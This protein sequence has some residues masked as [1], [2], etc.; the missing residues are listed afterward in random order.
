MQSLLVDRGKLELKQ[1]DGY[2]HEFEDVPVFLKQPLIADKRYLDTKITSPVRVSYAPNDEKLFSPIEDRYVGG[3][4]AIWSGHRSVVVRDPETRQL[5]RLKGIAFNEEK[6]EIKEYSPGAL[7]VDG[8]QFLRYAVN[9]KI[10]SDR[11]NHTLRNN[12]MEPVMEVIGLYEYPKR[13]GRQ[14]IAATISRIK[15]DTRLDELFCMFELLYAMNKIHENN[16]EDLKK[17]IE[18][19]YM[20][21]GF[22]SGAHKKMMTDNKQTWSAD[23]N[24]TNAHFGNI[25]VYR[26][27]YARSLDIGFVDFDSS[28]KPSEVDYEKQIKA[29]LNSMAEKAKEKE[30]SMRLTH[31]F[32]TT[33]IENLRNIFI[34]GFGISYYK[35]SLLKNADKVISNTF[36]LGYNYY[37][38]LVTTM[39]DFINKVHENDTECKL[40]TAPKK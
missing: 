9:E 24:I 8:G 22:I 28:C 25:V 30:C 6:P 13:V 15:G 26:S 11:F 27:E 2:L 39:T 7:Y 19:F 31:H 33:E 1:T 20:I 29:E 34:A 17:A 21:S 14:K 23:P 40:Q 32:K 5:Y 18:H 35:A 12:G 38:K 3:V 16:D 4:P 36:F 10:F 37:I